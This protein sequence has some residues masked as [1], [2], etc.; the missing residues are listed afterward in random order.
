MPEK[1]YT[2]FEVSRICGVYP[3]TVINW[4]KQ[5][6]LPA[7]VTPGGHRRIKRDDL[8]AFLKKYNFPTPPE[9]SASRKRVL[10]VDDDADFARTMAK[11]FEKHR[12]EF[13]PVVM[14]NGIEAL[15][16]LGKRTP[17]LVILDVVMPIVDGGTVCATL[18]ES[19]ETKGIK[20]IAVSGK[21]LQDRQVKYFRA[22]ADAFLTKPFDMDD[23][24]KKAADL[25]RVD[26]AAPTY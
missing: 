25:L 21:K 7:F 19:P 3:T 24:V 15:V 10:I 11:A 1:T 18:K 20:I 12:S 6:K 13:E 14:T 9:L 17:D 23:L 16:S 4:V 5:A 2:T 22:K 26:L 8:V